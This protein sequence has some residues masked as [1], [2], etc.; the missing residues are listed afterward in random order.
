VM[1]VESLYS[2]ARSTPSFSSES[3]TLSSDV[4]YVALVAKKTSPTLASCV[5][6]KNAFDADIDSHVPACL[7]I[8]P[9]SPCLFIVL[10]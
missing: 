10:K 8:T 9:L 3:I 4:D 6:Y 1:R 7:A 2:S 5:C